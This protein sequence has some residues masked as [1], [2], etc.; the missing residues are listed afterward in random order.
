MPTVREVTVELLRELGMTT[1]F[2]NPGSTELPMLKELPG[3]FRYVM[4]LHEGAVVGMADGYAQGTRRAALVNLHTSAGLGNA[5]GAIVTACHNRAPLVVTAGQQDRRHLALEPMLSGRLVELARPYVKWSNEPARAQDVPR[6]LSRAYHTAMQHP[7]GPVFVS[8]PMDDW[9]K[10]ASPLESRAVSHRTAPDPESLEAAARTLRESRNPAMVAGGG[11]DRC[12]AWKEAVLLAE[13]LRAPVWAAPVWPQAGFPQAHPLFRGHLPPAQAAI[14][15]RLS[16]HDAVLVLGAPVFLYYPYVPGPVLEPGT[17][18]VH[19]TEDPQEAAYAAAGTSVVG[20]VA[21]AAR[22]LLELLPEIDRELPEPSPEPPVP[23]ARTP[24]PVDYVACELARR[25]PEDAILTDE[26]SS[27]MGI[28]GRYLRTSRPGSYYVTGSGGLGFA[29]PAAV[30]LQLASPER[31]VVCVV[32]DGASLYAPQALWSAARY[33]AP[34]LF[35]VLN[36]G[37]YAILKAFSEFIETGKNI[38]SLDLPHLDIP[39]IAEGF[40]CG[41]G[42]AE[43]PE[44]LGTELDRAL[45]SDRPYLLNVMVDRRVEPL[46]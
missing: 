26:A 5:M 16:G 12:G 33:G 7:R 41:A 9:D 30:G 31:R 36:N 2:G 10:E 45:S 34:V 24:L 17:A 25:M 19:I 39:R 23:E 14:A 28:T 38:P 42:T 43:R 29:M 3:D 44:E 11:V 20:D 8:I 18:L 46:V 4:G 32:G 15:Q 37:Q 1:I 27:H 35:V 6:T 21:L 13:R 40:G 22:G